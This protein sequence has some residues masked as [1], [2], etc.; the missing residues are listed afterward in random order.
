M[1]MRICMGVALLP[2]A[3]FPLLHTLLPPQD[4]L[5]GGESA[6]LQQQGVCG[7]D[8]LWV[9]RPQGVAAADETAH[10]PDEANDGNKRTRQNG[11]LAPPIT[12]RAAAD[13][14][15]SVSVAGPP[16]AI[17]AFCPVPA[18]LIA[19]PPALLQPAFD[20]DTEDVQPGPSGLK[21]TTAMGGAGE[22]AAL[23]GR[24]AAGPSGLKATNATGGAG[25]FT[26][27]AGRDA[28]GRADGHTAQDA[29]VS[30]D[31]GTFR[32]EEEG[33]GWAEGA[34]SGQP[35]IPLH[36]KRVLSAACSS[37]D[38]DAGA[39]GRPWSAHALLL[40]AVHAAMLETGFA[41]LQVRG[42]VI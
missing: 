4:T 36:L 5:M 23:A 3:C 14:P 34:F 39:L 20:M 8:T 15:A 18:M 2:H 28:A 25:G 37:R 12:G 22:F 16:V 32:E 26:T 40:A 21:A 11:S 9:M 33:E 17:A 19:G 42:R 38:G 1:G 30:M 6:L 27:L 35:G 41:S 7:G 24:D 29:H 31:T 10:P 13:A